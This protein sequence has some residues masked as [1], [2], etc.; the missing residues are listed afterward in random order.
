MKSYSNTKRNMFK[1]SNGISAFNKAA[2]NPEIVE[3]VKANPE[4]ITQKVSLGFNEPDDPE[5]TVNLKMNVTGP[6]Y[7][8]WLQKAKAKRDECFPNQTFHE[9]EGERLLYGRLS[10]TCTAADFNAEEI[11]EAFKQ[12]RGYKRP[13]EKEGI[14]FQVEKF[15]DQVVI[16]LMG[17]APDSEG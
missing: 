12:T 3:F 8:N 4:T 14:D 16:H 2:A 17:I 6:N 15:D 11:I 1:A 7:Q 10:V 13:H 5:T 9:E